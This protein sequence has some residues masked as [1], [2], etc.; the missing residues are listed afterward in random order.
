MERI[1]FGVHE[2]NARSRAALRKVGATQEGVLRK[3]LP[4]TSGMM[5]NQRYDIIL[6]SLMKGEWKDQVKSTLKSE[7]LA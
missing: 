1:G 4:D 6:F 5:N 2:L 7:V 3:F